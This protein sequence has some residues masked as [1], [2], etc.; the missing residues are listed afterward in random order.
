MTDFGPLIASPK[1]ALIGIGGQLGIFVAMGG[2]L[3][4]G[5]IIPGIESFTL[6]EA[7]SIGIIGSSDG[8]TSIYTAG[9]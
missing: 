8:P 1:S 5:H 6:K 9:F 7:A 3:L 4:I 2:A